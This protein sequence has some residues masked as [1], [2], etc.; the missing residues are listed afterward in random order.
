M[1]YF[2]ISVVPPKMNGIRLG[3][4]TGLMEWSCLFL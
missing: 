2:M 4:G 1:I 3:S